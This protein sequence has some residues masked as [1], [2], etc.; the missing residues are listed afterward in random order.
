LCYHKRPHFSKFLHRLILLRRE[1]EDD[2]LAH[3]QY[4][5]H[6]HQGGIPA[7]ASASPASASAS[8]SSHTPSSASPSSLLHSNTPEPVFYP[9]NNKIRVT[10]RDVL[11][12]EVANLQTQHKQ[13]MNLLLT[14][15]DEVK[16]T[17]K[18]VKDM[19]RKYNDITKHH[20]PV[21][22]VFPSVLAP[23][24]VPSPFP[25]T[26]P[27]PIYI[28]KQESL[29]LDQTQLQQHQHQH[30]QQ[31]TQ[32]HPQ[33]QHQHQQQHQ[34]QQQTSVCPI[35][36]ISSSASH[37]QPDLI[38]TGPLS[39]TM[40]LDQSLSLDLSSGSTTLFMNG[41]LGIGEEEGEGDDIL[42]RLTR[43][44]DVLE[45][46]LA[47]SHTFSPAFESYAARHLNGGGVGGDSTTS[48]SPSS[49]STLSSDSPY[50]GVQVL[51]NSFD[52][53]L[54]IESLTEELKNLANT[55]Q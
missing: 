19:Q 12:E 53:V 10:E 36:D 15:V 45:Q 16:D 13:I 11:V 33:P 25:F 3:Q 20:V 50:P 43:Q 2:D 48:P 8:V 46:L 4:L 1:G 42:Q 26:T 41:S 39:P 34:P 24:S 29:P 14:L 30:Q 18:K 23:S 38:G 32:L 9:P 21:T 44:E 5:H 51:P 6:I 17:K 27:T 35:N 31:Q 40:Y 55:G 37:V 47:N 28:V 7:G 22:S 54:Q 49:S 52:S